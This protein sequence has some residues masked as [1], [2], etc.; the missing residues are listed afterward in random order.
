[1]IANPICTE[2]KFHKS[3]CSGDCCGH[4][5]RERR[6]AIDPITGTPGFAT[7][8]GG[9]TVI[10]QYPYCHQYNTLENPCELFQEKKI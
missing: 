1:M 5:E 6:P 2:C 7:E 3:T 8:D 4:P 10:S 9:W